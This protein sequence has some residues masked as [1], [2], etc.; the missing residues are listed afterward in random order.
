MYDH[1]FLERFIR[2]K[3]IKAEVVYV[4]E[5]RT[6]L[7][8]ARSLGVGLEEIAKTIIFSGG[9]GE[10][11]AVVVGARH[12]VVQGKLARILGFKRLRLARPEEIVEWTGYP[13]G[14][15][16]PVAHKRRIRVIVDRE[17]LGRSFVYAGG[18]TPRHLLR[19]SPR[20]IVALAGAE[21]TDVPKK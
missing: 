5:A 2:E 17:L 9:G 21:V 11:V 4:G 6:S 1:R 19:I 3:N 20:D 15:V 16:P 18:G 10:L 12:R 7:E 8:A 14:G 13:P